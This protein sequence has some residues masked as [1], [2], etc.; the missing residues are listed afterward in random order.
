VGCS[1]SNFTSDAGK[2]S[3][4]KTPTDGTSTDASGDGRVVVDC[5]QKTATEC[6]AAVTKV[7][8]DGSDGKPLVRVTGC[9]DDDK[10]T[11]ASIPSV[12]S[13]GQVVL[14]PDDGGGVGPSGSIQSGG[15]STSTGPGLETGGG[16]A[17]TKTTDVPSQAVSTSNSPFL[18][19]PGGGANDYGPWTDQHGFT[20]DP[21]KL[22]V[23]GLKAGDEL[24]V[25]EVSG[26]IDDGDGLK[27]TCKDGAGTEQ[28]ILKHL[29]ILQLTNED[30]KVQA[31]GVSTYQDMGA[32]PV[33]DL[34]DTPLTIPSGVTKAYIGIGDTRY[35][36]NG[37]QCTV[38]IQVKTHVPCGP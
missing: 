3:G 29:L 35:A 23:D 37:S 30:G 15:G 25:T 36:D 13:P 33:R 6:K 14:A 34:I 18:Q 8:A 19:K 21:P 11:C 16:E 38:K 24:R 32:I 28:A 1:S 26:K 9:A 7:V 2:K 20:P 5:S 22:V 10:T 12:G 31:P 17:C 27:G 4:A